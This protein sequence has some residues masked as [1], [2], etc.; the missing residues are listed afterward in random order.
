LG[1]CGDRARRSGGRFQRDRLFAPPAP[2]TG[3]RNVAI[4]AAIGLAL[5][6]GLTYQDDLVQIALRVCS[7]IVPA[8]PVTTAPHTLAVTESG[9]G[10]FYIM[11]AV[12]GAPVRFLVDTGS[13]D[14]ALSPADAKRL[15]VDLA[16]L[17]FDNVT[18]TANGP[19][20]GAP[21]TA[22]SLAVGPIQFSN[23]AMSINRSDMSS[24]LLGMSFFKRLDSFEMKDRQLIMKWRS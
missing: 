20:R 19:G 7:T 2:W 22:A 23:V 8:Y 10:G 18:E 14:I 5:I 3:G 24:S 21:F 11:G 15:G 12:N 9:D 16:H 17:T 6:L 1:Q 4:W 13:S